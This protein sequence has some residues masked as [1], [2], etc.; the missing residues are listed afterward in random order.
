MKKL[1]L[2][3][4]LIA[5]FVGLLQFIKPQIPEIKP[6]KSL[7]GIPVEVNAIIRNSCF[8]CHSTQTEISWYDKLT[9]ANYFVY[10]H[11]LRGRQAM[12]FSK[13]DSLAPAV[14]NAK[15]YYSLNKI[16]AD[17]MPLPSYVIFHKKAKLSSKDIEILKKFLKTRTP[18]KP[19]DSIQ[20]H[21]ANQQFSDFIQK[22]QPVQAAPNGIEYISEYRNWKVISISDRFDNGSLRMIYGNDI[23]VKAIQSH[24]INPWPD[25]AILAK[26]AWKQQSSKDGSISSGEFIQVEFMIKDAQK[27]NHTAGW[28]WA[29][30]RGI[31]LKPYGKKAIFTT[32]CTSCHKPVKDNDYVFTKPLYLKKYLHEI[33]KK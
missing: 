18:R 12:D 14:Q 33:N 25:G 3:L 24:T 19:F 30:W 28:G 23:A 29:R 16:L 13:W 6:V 26:A 27:Y 31:D 32:E 17:E 1:S 7:T 5:V 9:P 21:R 8:D 2:V 10:D 15:L 20:I 4:F 11:I 22:K